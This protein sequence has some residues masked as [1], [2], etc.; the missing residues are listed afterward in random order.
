MS[1]LLAVLALGAQDTEHRGSLGLT[2][3]VAPQVQLLSGVLLTAYPSPLAI[4]LEVGATWG[5]FDHTEL[6]LAA[7]A[8]VP[9]PFGIEFHAGIRNSYGFSSLKSFFDAEAVLQVAPLLMPGLRLAG[10][11]QFDFSSVAGVYAGAAV[12]F[13]GNGFGTRLSVEVNVGLQ[14]RTYVFQ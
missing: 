5:A 1:F 3:A 11:L 4:P 6:R 9:L 12:Q 10:G 8:N 7:R 2:V 13:V 14:F